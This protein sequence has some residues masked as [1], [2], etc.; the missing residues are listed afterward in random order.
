MEEAGGNEEQDLWGG[1]VWNQYCRVSQ[2]RNQ[3]WFYLT[4]KRGGYA[5]SSEAVVVLGLSL[6]R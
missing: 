5:C 3:W 2:L 4:C 6:T 1:W